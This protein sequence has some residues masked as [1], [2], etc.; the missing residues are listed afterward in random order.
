MK[1]LLKSVLFLSI[2]IFLTSCSS[3]QVTIKSLQPSIMHDKKI[4]KVIIEDLEND[5][6]NQ[7]NYI[8]EK[9]INTIV[10][11]KRVFKLETSYD[12]I[13]AIITGEVLESSLF[14]DL[15][16]EED[17]DYKRCFRYKYENGK[18]TNKCIEFRIK[19]YPCENRDYNVKTRIEVLNKDEELIFSKTYNKSANKRVCYKNNINFS[20]FFYRHTNINRQKEEI[21][22]SLARSISKDLVK[23]LSPHYKYQ[24]ISIIEELDDKNNLYDKNI[25][26][27]FENIVE[28]LDNANINISNL[29]LIDLNNKLNSKSYEVLYN[30][31]LT[32]EAKDELY[33][34]KMYYIEAANLA[35]KVEDLK[36]IDKAINRTQ[37]NLENKIKA[38]SQL[39]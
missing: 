37:K 17:T 6:I 34:A 14:F 4:Y 25:K 26:K 18:K 31:A 23:D 30:L 39:Q 27:E 22:S 24:K 3:K 5:N 29:K 12:N 10:D 2:I 21:N 19:R 35:T 28:L 7:A 15:Y 13:D 1:I 11:N 36:L 9:L 32:Y 20:L 8:E 33:K 38:K 16:Y